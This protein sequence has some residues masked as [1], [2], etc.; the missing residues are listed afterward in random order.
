MH[1][2]PYFCTIPQVTR[3]TS[4]QTETKASEDDVQKELA[5]ATDKGRELLSG[6]LG[7]QCLFYTTGWWTYSFCY[8]QQVRQFHALSPAQVGGNHWPPRE[9]P[10][11]P[12]FVLGKVD[13]ATKDPAAPDQQS[14]HAVSTELQTRAETSYL[15]QRL[16]GGTECDLTGKERKIEIEFHC[17][18]QLTDRIGWI[19]E[20]STCAYQMVVYTPRLCGDVAF[21]PPKGS[22]AHPIICEEILTEDQLHEHESAKSSEEASNLAEQEPQRPLIVGKTVVGGMKYLADGKKLERGRVVLTQDE[23][24][25]VVIMQKDGKVSSVSPGDLKKLEIDPEFIESFRKELEKAA[26]GKDWKIEKLDDVNGQIQLRG[27]VSDDDEKVDVEKVEVKKG[28]AAK[29]GEKEDGPVEDE[30]GDGE[31]DGDGDGAEEYREEI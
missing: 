10:A 13:G 18:P 15:V 16:E 29:D 3:S 2:V 22:K 24:A 31:G 8:N 6:M 27:T 12:A 30:A 23:R 28:Q 25:E 19:K 17:N 7:G 9:D 5:R 21:L 20:T 1:E 4:N 11:T 14:Q 26:G